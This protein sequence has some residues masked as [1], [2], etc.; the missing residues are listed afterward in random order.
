MY[1]L[2]CTGRFFNPIKAGMFRIVAV[3]AI[4]DDESSNSRITL[5]DG[6]GEVLPDTYDNKKGIVDIKGIGNVDGML[7]FSPI[8]PIKVING[9]SSVETSNIVAGTLKVYVR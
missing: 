5:V 1:P 4:V 7:E 6:P 3:S 9:I 8:E 2:Q